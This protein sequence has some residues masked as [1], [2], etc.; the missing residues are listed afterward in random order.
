M[1]KYLHLSAFML[2]NLE[3]LKFTLGNHSSYARLQVNDFL[4]VIP[5]PLSC[6]VPAPA[7]LDDPCFS[8]MQKLHSEPPGKHA[9]SVALYC[10]GGMLN[11]LE[12]LS[13]DIAAIVALD[14]DRSFLF[15]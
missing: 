7:A 1:K 6:S 3:L 9:T 11:G 5:V 12:F 10:D 15:P 14:C 2:T 8:F 4:H 13:A